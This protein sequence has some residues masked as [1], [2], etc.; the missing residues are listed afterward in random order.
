MLQAI[1]IREMGWTWQEYEQQPTWLIHELV[2]YLSAEAQ[3]SRRQ[4]TG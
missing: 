2:A 3:H 1:L 4:S